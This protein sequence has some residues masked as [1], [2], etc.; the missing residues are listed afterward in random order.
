MD[1][2]LFTAGMAAGAVSGLA[3]PSTAFQGPLDD[4]ETRIELLQIP[5][6]RRL[7][8]Q[9]RNA[10][11][12]LQDSDVSGMRR[13]D[14]RLILSPQLNT[15]DGTPRIRIRGLVKDLSR[16]LLT[17]D[18]T[19]AGAPRMDDS[20]M[21][22]SGNVYAT[23]DPAILVRRPQT[24]LTLNDGETIVIGGLLHQTPNQAVERD[25]SLP[26]IG[27]LPV[28]GHAF[29]STTESSRHRELVIFVTARL[30]QP[31]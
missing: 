25:L 11:R 9:F 13:T 12:V 15:Q 28:I 4:E 5:D 14:L 2:R 1:R 22:F 23:G 29:R 7:R 21:E 8:S 26:F 16:P 3:S 30:I 27:D 31:E 18:G 10:P 20:D 19:A 24:V 6:L 17:M